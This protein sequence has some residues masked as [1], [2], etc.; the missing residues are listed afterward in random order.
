MKPIRL[1]LTLTGL[2][3]FALQPVRA[4]SESRLAIIQTIDGPI[5]PATQE[6]LS[7][8]IKVAQQRA[9]EVLIVQLNTPGGGI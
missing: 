1:L 6:Y 9:A 4:Q 3:L 7:R 5:T 2:F 8:G